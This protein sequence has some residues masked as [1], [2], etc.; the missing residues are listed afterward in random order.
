[1]GGTPLRPP[2]ECFPAPGRKGLLRPAHPLGH[3]GT[4][5]WGALR[6]VSRLHRSATPSANVLGVMEN[7]PRVKSDTAP[8]A[9]LH[10]RL[11]HLTWA[12]P[13]RDSPDLTSQYLMANAAIA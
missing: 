13:G 11:P 12:V 10:A 2:G 7:C 1:M 5:G 4:S 6:L 8:G 9:A 3:L